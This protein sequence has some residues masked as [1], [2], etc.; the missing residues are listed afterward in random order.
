MT[1]DAAG[2]GATMGAA[3][4]VVT[5][6]GDGSNLTGLGLTFFP[7]SYDPGISSTNIPTGTNI[8]LDWNHPVK[9]GSG[10]ITIRSGSASGTVVDQFV[11]GTS[12]SI[13]FVNNQVILDPAA[14]L[15]NEIEYFVTYPA[16]SIKSYGDKYQ[17]D[18]LIY[19]FTTEAVVYQL[20]MWGA[21][22][23]GWSGNTAASQ[24]SSPVQVSGTDWATVRAGQAS[25]FSVKTNGTL[26]SW[27]ANQYGQLGQNQG[28]PYP[29]KT[30]WYSS[31]TQVGSGTDWGKTNK[32]I[33]AGVMVQVIKT[34][35]T[36]WTWGNSQNQGN[37]G[38][39]N[40]TQYSSPTQVGTDTTWSDCS[41]SCH[42]TAMVIKTDGTLWSWG[43]G[44]Y[45]QLGLNEAGASNDYSSP[46]QIGTDT[47]WSKAFNN[48][49]GQAT[50]GLKTNG[51]LWVWGNNINGQLGLN[52]THNT[53][54]RS[55]PTQIPGTDWS[56]VSSGAYGG[57]EFL[58]AQKTNGT[59]WVWGNNAEGQLGQ[60]N[61][62]A[63]SS[64]TQVPGTWD[65]SQLSQKKVFGF[66]TDGTL[67]SW[68]YDWQGNLGLNGGGNPGR[69]SS[70]TQVGTA[71]NWIASGMR[72][73]AFITA[74]L[75]QG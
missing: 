43:D 18:Q 48:G 35:G 55:S 27:G 44:Y 7:I 2:L 63:L 73:N 29:S 37:L 13:S 70:P 10:T 61:V 33:N 51:T 14:D 11:V 22:Q 21:N 54:H 46:M 26:W 59:M 23:V 66:K 24:Y 6:F 34:D 42:Q 19:S 64:P 68:G 41:G 45:G 28:A 57:G 20:W 60:N 40:Q 39:N 36:L 72:P 67:W 47:T 15:S 49:P 32:H 5:Y 74:A 38:L 30:A 65:N 53:A 9:A 62:V 71:T 52:Q 4:G 12:S 1:K 50:L 69:R 16:G 3:V 31:P 75:R 25:V 8:T 17:N 56:H 58:M